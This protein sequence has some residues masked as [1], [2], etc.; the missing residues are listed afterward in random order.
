MHVEQLWRCAHVK[1]ATSALQQ[2]PH[3][4][5]L[6][7]QRWRRIQSSNI[8]FIQTDMAADCQYLDLHSFRPLFNLETA[9]VLLPAFPPI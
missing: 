7:S 1:S 3:C 9:V 8:T 6:A 5:L 4:F 2:H